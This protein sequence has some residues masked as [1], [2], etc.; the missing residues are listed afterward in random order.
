MTGVAV[1][2][3][4]R[5]PAD[6]DGPLRVAVVAP[7]WFEVPPEGYGGIESVVA[8]L[9]E[10]LVA[11][12]HHVTLVAAGRDR[13]AAERFVQTFAVPPTGRLG[14]AVPEV[15]H[16]AVAG[17]DMAWCLIVL[18]FAPAITVVGYEA[19]G[20]RHQLRALARQGAA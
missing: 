4:S 6:P 20:H 18:M 15:L 9:V 3:P 11:L 10:V 2:R 13:T 12:G 16:A 5:E 19:A 7:P 1:A 14:A 8:D 17:V